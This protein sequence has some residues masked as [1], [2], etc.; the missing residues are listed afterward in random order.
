MIV[1]TAERHDVNPDRGLAVAIF[2]LVATTYGFFFGGG[3]WNQNAQFDLTRAI[4]E[5]RSLTIDRYAGNT[6]DRSTFGGHLYANKSPGTS[7]LAVIPYSIAFALE[8]SAGIDVDDPIAMSFN[9]YLCTF[10]VC[11]L[12]GALIPALLFLHARSLGFRRGWSLAVALAIAFATPLFAYA[13]VL[14]AHV[15]S[16]ALL[17]AAYVLAHKE[18]TR[19]RFVAGMAAGLAGMTNYLCIPLLAVVGIVVLRPAATRVR[20]AIA[21]TL[22]VVP[23]ML[24]IAAYQF[25][26]FGSFTTTPIATMDPRFVAKHAWLGIIQTPSLEALRGITISPYRGLFFLSPVLVFAL[27]GAVVMWRMRARFSFGVIAALSLFLVVFNTTFNGWEGGFA[28]GPR[29]LV[30]MIPFLGIAMLYAVDLFRPLWI[31]LAV[32][33]FV[34]NFAAVAVD[35]TPSGTIPR[36]LTQYIFPLLIHG[37]FSPDVPIT[38]PWSAATIRGHVSVSPHS[39]DQI[40]PFVK[41]SPGSRETQWASFNLGEPLLGAGSAASLLP[42]LAWM[43]AG[44]VYLARRATSLDEG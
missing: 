30:P 7:F 15:P 1:R 31:A 5:Q 34:A 9:L 40:V 42:V 36:P 44:A 26:A 25:A 41:H 10:F 8:R 2:L 32:V 11:G 14:F 37:E 38:P 24:L 21:Y 4:V 3:G 19:W 23:P 33:S 18:Q 28:I 16:A 35:P 27:G 6:G 29:Y 43:I 13:T 17:F 20:S 22:G 39:A 12:L